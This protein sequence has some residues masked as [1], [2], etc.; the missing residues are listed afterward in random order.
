MLLNFNEV[1]KVTYNRIYN[2][3]VKKDLS[4]Q[5]LSDIH[6]SEI[7][8]KNILDNL[9]YQLQRQKSDYICILG[10]LIDQQNYLEDKQNRKK[11]YNFLKVAGE[12][13]PTLIILG[14]HDL[15][16][17]NHEYPYTKNWEEFTQI[18]NVY[19]LNNNIYQDKNIFVM[20]ILQDMEY[21]NDHVANKKEF[22]SF[23]Q[24]IQSNSYLYENIPTNL[25][26]IGL[27]HSPEFYQDARIVELLKDF[28]LIMC[29]HTHQGCLPAILENIY[30]KNAGLISPAYKLFPK[31]VRGIY[32]LDT[33]T[34]LL[35]TGGITKIGKTSPK[36]LHYWNNLCYK[37]MDIVTLTND[38]NIENYRTTSQKV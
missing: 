36:V 15:Y 5:V 37:H 33:K 26:I 11:L 27:L 31:V 12:T 22:N 10:D 1:L 35:I 32:T 24:E 3:K 29:G 17:K 30:P 9:N 28:D 14:N 16:D 7:V 23:Y 6:L 2:N 38:E 18:P 4:F 34:N 19:M 21:Y 8:L 25:P 13:A 20:G